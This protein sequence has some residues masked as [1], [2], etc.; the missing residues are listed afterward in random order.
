MTKKLK[1][2][3]GQS[4]AITPPHGLGHAYVAA[5]SRA[6]ACRVIEEY[7]GRKFPA[8]EIR[9]YW[10]EGRWGNSMDHIVPERG[11][12][13]KSSSSV[14]VRVVPSGA[15]SKLVVPI[16]VKV[17]HDLGEGSMTDL[18][19]ASHLETVVASTGNPVQISDK[20]IERR[21]TAVNY[22]GHQ[23]KYLPDML[24]LT[25]D[26]R[27]AIEAALI[28]FSRDRWFDIQLKEHQ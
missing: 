5:Y 16:T 14:P 22:V 27:L 6:D 26:E 17:G 9:D 23:I 2:Y 21:W 19:K 13:L 15:P 12:W 10:S 24:L 28:I 25:D 3:D 18:L 7:T 1:L 11:L 8:N 20:E 4:V